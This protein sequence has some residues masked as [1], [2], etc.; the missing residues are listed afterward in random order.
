MNNTILLFNIYKVLVFQNEISIA[1]IRLYINLLVYKI[2][3]KS[4]KGTKNRRID[5]VKYEGILDN[6][7]KTLNRCL[8]S[9]CNQSYKDL[10][11]ICVNDGSV[12]NSLYNLNEYSKKDLG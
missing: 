6:T 2:Y 5:R 1:L 8:D 9:I 11:I 7:E 10:E 3:K 12:D 4:T